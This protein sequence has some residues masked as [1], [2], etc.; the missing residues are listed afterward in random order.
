MHLCKSLAIEWKAFARVNT[1]SPGFV[2]TGMSDAPGAKEVLDLAYARTPLGRQADPRELKGVRWAVSD[3]MV[4]GLIGG[5]RCI[6]T[7]RATRRLSRPVPVSDFHCWCR[8]TLTQSSR[9][10]RRWRVYRS[11]SEG[12]ST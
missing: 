4:S 8:R 2:A 7:W 9:L 11:I 5:G 12:K 10:C 3:N 6:C 1:V